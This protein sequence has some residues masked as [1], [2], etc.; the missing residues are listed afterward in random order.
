MMGAPRESSLLQDKYH[1]HLQRRRRRRK[2]PTKEVSHP[3]H[4]DNKWWDQ[5]VVFAEVALEAEPFFQRK[6]IATSELLAILGAARPLAQ[7]A[8]IP[9]FVVGPPPIKTTRVTTPST[10]FRTAALTSPKSDKAFAWAL[11][12]AEGQGRGREEGK[13]GHAPHV[14]TPTSEA[15]IVFISEAPVTTVVVTPTP[16]TVAIEATLV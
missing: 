16:V 3:I 11:N 13:W 9:V 5:E 1:P 15:A 8:A 14:A 7:A 6:H 4:P 2:A 10:S 12:L